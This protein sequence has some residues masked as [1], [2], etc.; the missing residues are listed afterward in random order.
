MPA[1]KPQESAPKP[2]ALPPVEPEDRPLTT[3]QLRSIVLIEGNHG[4]ATGF[5]T[6]YRDKLFVATNL[7]V[8]GDNQK[9][10]VKTID[11]ETLAV[12]G[13]IGAVGADIA[14]LRV[15]RPELAPPQLPL[16]SDVIQSS[17]I[18]DMVTVVGNRL[19]GGVATQVNGKVLGLGPDRIEVDARFQPGNSGSPVIQRKTGE[20]IGIATYL[21][22]VQIDESKLKNGSAGVRQSGEKRWFAY[23]FD[24]VA[25]WE[26]IDWARWQAQTKRLNDFRENSLALLALV[27]GNTPEA[28]SHPKLRALIDE[29]KAS[30]RDT[31]I[32]SSGRSADE[33][34]AIQL[35]G[36]LQ[37]AQSFAEDGLRAFSSDSYYDFFRSEP[38][39]ETSVPK[40]VEFRNQ[41]IKA[42]K[43][44]NSDLRGFQMRVGR[45]GQHS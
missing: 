22:N 44:I 7:H 35:R 11:G 4:V 28:A 39:W 45:T 1:P 20:V 40:Q 23:R 6:T 5:V 30:L 14:L 15:T 38:Y 29:Y 18:E 16:A 17:K 27:E 25:R 41:L 9:L 31:T 37:G 19:G 43:E 34:I 36:M 33:I 42:L 3:D 13:I 32:L 10:V 8:L 26:T 2:A 12:S 24:T 21:E